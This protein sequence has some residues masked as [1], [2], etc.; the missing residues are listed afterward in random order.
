MGVAIAD[1]GSLACHNSRPVSVSKARKVR[2]SVAPMNVRP[3]AVVSGPPNVGVPHL[4]DS[5]M[6]ASSRIVPSGACHRMRPVLASTAARVPHGGGLQGRCQ[7]DNKG[8]RRITYG[9]RKKVAYGK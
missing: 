8:R 3:L 2:S 5:G 9:D 1:A 4:T 6:G 7:G